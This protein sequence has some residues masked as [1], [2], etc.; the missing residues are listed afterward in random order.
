[1][2]TSALADG[3]FAAAPAAFDADDH[4][5]VLWASAQEPLKARIQWRV[6][7]VAQSALAQSANN[8]WVNGPEVA[9]TT[10]T[11]LTQ[12]TTITG[13]P[14]D[15]TIEYRFI[16]AGAS[17]VTLSAGKFKTSSV[18]AQPCR[19][20]FS[21]DMQAE[22]K[23][24]S[25]FD[26]MAAAR[27][28]FA[29]LLGDTIY[30]DVPKR[31]FSGTLRGY[32]RKHFE[33]RRDSAL[34]SFL[35]QHTCY[36]TWDDH[37]TDNNSDATHRSMPVARDVF[38]EYWPCRSVT[39]D[40]LYR[41]FGWGGCDFLMLD[42]RSF[43]SSNALPDGPEK[44][45][46]GVVQKAWLKQQ[47]K[48]SRAPFKFVITSVPFQGGGEDTWGGFKAERQEIEAYL[49]SEQIQG[50]IFLTG[51]YHLAR[52]WTRRG[53]GYRE[54]MVGPIASFVHYQHTPAARARYQNAG[55]FHHGDSYN[56]GLIEVD[57]AKGRGWIEWRGVKG[58]VLGRVEFTT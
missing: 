12:S 2:P 25:L 15:K 43:R 20:V 10:D 31:E 16:E 27:P 36:A 19:F 6:P 1:M 17:S 46:L 9:F 57:P 41:R 55:T 4:S 52:D 11:D 34:Q 32:R 50:L 49:R 38:R 48:Q 35:N 54:Y 58:T 51:D 5:V 39:S 26:D 47:L 40:G 44:T 18:Q 29:I 30:A 28:D 45:M 53:A 7:S 13:L 56:F 33:N 3:K 24:F 8:T 22:Y 14:E 42:T 21:A 37:E 23:P